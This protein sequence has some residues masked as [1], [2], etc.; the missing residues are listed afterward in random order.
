M[1]IS[2]VDFPAILMTPGPC[3]L[4]LLGESSK[5]DVSRHARLKP[6]LGSFSDPM[7]GAT[8][9]KQILGTKSHTC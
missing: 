1:P 8:S 4:V 3:W 5:L 7:G 2:F 9:S 6:E